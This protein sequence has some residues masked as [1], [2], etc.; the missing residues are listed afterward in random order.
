MSWT[1]EL[2]QYLVNAPFPCTKKELIEYAIRTNCPREVIDNCMNLEDDEDKIYESIKDIWPDYPS[3]DDYL[4][5]P[6][7]F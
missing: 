6:S 1:L 5:D 4:Y 2:I 3:E 7:E